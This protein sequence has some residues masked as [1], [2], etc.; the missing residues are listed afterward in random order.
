MRF[1]GVKTNHSLRAS[2]FS[3]GYSVLSACWGYEGC[4]FLPKPFKNRPTYH[5]AF[6]W[7]HCAAFSRPVVLQTPSPEASQ[8][9]PPRDRSF[10][11]YAV[12]P[13]TH[14]LTG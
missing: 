13:H 8:L 5:G 1:M 10:D 2:S 11:A 4:V 14:N 3:L 6:V 12:S 7:F 9:L